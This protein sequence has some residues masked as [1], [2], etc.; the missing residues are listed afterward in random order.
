LRNTLMAD[1]MQLI[2]SGLAAQ[3]IKIGDQAPSFTLPNAVGRTVALAEL[4]AQGP[5]V[6]N[7]YRGAWC[8]YCNLER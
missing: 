3:S 2:Q 8:P 7:F 4:L 6:V 1:T 5:V